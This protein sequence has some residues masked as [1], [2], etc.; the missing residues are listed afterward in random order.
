MNQ[1]ISESTAEYLL[2]LFQANKMLPETVDLC[3]NYSKLVKSYSTQEEAKLS[4]I[5]NHYMSSALLNL[6]N[7]G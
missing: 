7:A 1:E 3:N 5:R 4:D 6:P 2:Y